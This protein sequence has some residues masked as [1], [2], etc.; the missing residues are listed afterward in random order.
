MTIKDL[1]QQVLEEAKKTRASLSN[2][3]LAFILF[4]EIC[5]KLYRRL[6]RL[7]DQT[8]SQHLLYESATILDPNAVWQSKHGCFLDFISEIDAILK[9]NP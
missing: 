4:D 8:I 7:K 1:T 6:H 9:A 2:E 5:A 3:R